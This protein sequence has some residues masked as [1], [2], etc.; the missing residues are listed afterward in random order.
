MRAYRYGWPL[1]HKNNYMLNVEI[2]RKHQRA[3]HRILAELAD[4]NYNTMESWIYG[5]RHSGD[6]VRTTADKAQRLADA[7]SVPFEQL[8]RVP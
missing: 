2:F 6:L 8:W 1:K 3:T 7:M 5:R 4:V